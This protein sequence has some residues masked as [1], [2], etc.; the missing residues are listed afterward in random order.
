MFWPFMIP[1]TIVVGNAA[2]PEQLTEPQVIIRLGPEHIKAGGK[3][4]TGGKSVVQRIFIDQRPA[5]DVHQYGATRQSVE[6]ST[7]DDAVSVRLGRGVD[8]KEVAMRQH[9]MERRE[10]CGALFK[11]RRQTP[12]LMVE[13]GHIETPSPPRDCTADP[14]QPKDSET[15]A[16]ETNTKQIALAKATAPALAHDAV[17]LAS[18]PGGAKQHH[19]GKV[20]G[21]VGK[22]TRRVRH[23]QAV[24][25]GRR[26][27]DVVVTD[28]TGRADADGRGEAGNDVRAQRERM[29]KHD[30]F[31]AVGCGR[32][33]DL[34]GGHVIG[35]L[36]NQGIELSVGT[37][38]HVAREPG[39]Q[40]QAVLHEAGM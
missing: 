12:G 17:I 10:V 27:I 31:S 24:C 4:V 13:H 29:G 39:G 36:V 6:R 34:I 40:D 2:A 16:A 30:G 22:H 8:G 37:R 25:F 33:D 21:T 1:D 32:L 18:A 20:G 9:L 3:Q 38:D 11:L 15:L 26:D 5:R 7:V 35:A 23:N 14:A 28:G 19:E